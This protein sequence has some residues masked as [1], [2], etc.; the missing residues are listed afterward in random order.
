LRIII[1]GPPG[2]GKTTLAL[3][4]SNYLSIPYV[5]GDKIFWVDGTERDLEGFRSLVREKVESLDWIYEGHLSKTF[6]LLTPYNPMVIVMRDRFPA[7]FVTVIAE[8][9][10]KVI[11]NS[12]RSKAIKRI[13]HHL[14]HWKEIQSKRHQL[15]ANYERQNPK[16]VHYWDKNMETIE[17]LAERLK[18]H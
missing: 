14:K 10:G 18:S 9:L 2:S 6:D 12:D 11:T 3:K 16:L 15:I 7:H 1:A 8:D 4:L 13:F 5:C 17:K